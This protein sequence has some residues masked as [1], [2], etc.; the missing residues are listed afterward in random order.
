MDGKLRGRESAD[1]KGDGTDG[2][3]V[4][5]G[6]TAVFEVD[7]DGLTATGPV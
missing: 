2:S 7:E 1:G 5:D 6:S 3:G 4:A